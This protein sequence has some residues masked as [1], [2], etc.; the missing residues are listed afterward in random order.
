MQSTPA[1]PVAGLIDIPLPL[2]VSLW[3]QTWLSQIS[4]VV[5]VAAAVAALLWFV[6]YRRANRYRR[7]ALSEIDRIERA[8]ASR[9]PNE[10]AAQLAVLVRQTALTVFPRERVAPLAGAAWLD[11]LDETYGEHEFSRG[12]GRLLVEAPYD[13]TATTDRQISSLVDLT[14]HWIK[15]HHV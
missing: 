12:V 6:H 10:V 7:E 15:V 14:R 11:F 1:D 8:S 3:P 5:L 4:I 2:P 13:L 9:A